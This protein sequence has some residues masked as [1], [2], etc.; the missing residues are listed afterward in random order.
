V[1]TTLLHLHKKKELM[2][3][4]SLKIKVNSKLYLKNPES[5]K[6]GQN[7]I[8]NSIKM[9]DTIG[10][11]A[12]TFKK[13]SLKIKSPESSI[14]RYFENKHALLVYLT[15]WYWSWTAY[16][17]VFSTINISSTK[18][19]L[20]NAIDVLTKPVLED[21]SILWV[22]EVL[23]DRIINTESIK[24]YHTVNVDDENKKGFF[25]S[26]KNVVNRVSEM[27]IDINSTY[28]YPHM[29]ISTMV[30]G[31][32]QQRYFSEHL[33]KLTDVKEEANFIT[34]FYKQLIFNAIT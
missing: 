12:F 20:E 2:E 3:D 15:S 9:I 18:I 10:F 23:L 17:I 31:A 7:I 5:S 33:P 22:N 28:E 13:L 1:T 32:H 34:K 8:N 6:L 11:E 30:E 19:R 16:R 26:Y 14:Y 21:D 27:I 4:L 29:L 25:E 24:A